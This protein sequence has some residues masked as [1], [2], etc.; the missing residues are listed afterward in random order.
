[1]LWGFSVFSVALFFEI[2]FM[3]K[4]IFYTGCIILATLAACGPA[5][6]DREMMHRRAKVFQDSIANSIRA[7][8]AEAEPPSNTAP[9]PDTASQ[10]INPN[11][12]QKR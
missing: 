2:A 6:E 8:M 1:L 9:L 11:S 10:S 12:S 3:K 4:V 7:Q 5:A